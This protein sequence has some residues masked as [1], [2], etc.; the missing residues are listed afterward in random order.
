[1]NDNKA[2]I[3]LIIPCYNEE[4]RL[5]IESFIQ[6]SNVCNFLFVNDGST[7]QTACLI[8]SHLNSSNYLL[9]LG[10]NVG[11][12]EA[13]RLGILYSVS[14][15]TLSESEWVGFW[16]ADL[17]T[18]LSELN[19]FMKFASCQGVNIDAIW[20][21]RVYRLG[22]SIHRSYFRRILGRVF[23]TVAALLLGIESYDTQCGAKLFKRDIV[24]L[25]FSEK[26]ISKWIFD[27][28]ILMRLKYQ[29]VIEYPLHSWSDVIGSKL[30]VIS[31]ASNI[32]SDLVNIRMKY[33]RLVK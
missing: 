26:F 16:D 21:S 6:Y 17:A 27:L 19:G 10:K 18:P 23:A 25:A 12:A 3:C 28:E 33:G 22:S 4:K 31:S 15:P 29:N 32:L 20:G 11:K 24:H 7:D 8:K 2:K 9:D 14:H 1:M 30:N 5:Q 13:V